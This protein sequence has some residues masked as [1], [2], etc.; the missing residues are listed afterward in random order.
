MP[1]TIDVK[2]GDKILVG[3]RAAIVTCTESIYG[4]GVHG[5]NY[6]MP[7]GSGGWAS[8]SICRKISEE[9]WTALAVAQRM[10]GKH[11]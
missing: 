10:G 3:D 2:C 8:A 7:G 6:R 1:D 11:V 4:K 5:L 9:E